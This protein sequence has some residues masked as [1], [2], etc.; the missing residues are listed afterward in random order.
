[1]PERI[2]SHKSAAILKRHSNSDKK[3][4]H[5]A[6][7]LK[8][9]RSVLQEEP[10]CRHCLEQGI[11]TVATDVDHIIDR[12]KTDQSMWLDRSNLQPLCHSCHSKKTAT[13]L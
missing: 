3:F 8:L 1:M 12:S 4:L 11:T 10:L 2:K 9:R 7:W 13:T 6:A 5:S